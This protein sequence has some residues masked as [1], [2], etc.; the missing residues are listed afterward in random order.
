MPDCA[1]REYTTLDRGNMG[2]MEPVGSSGI[3]EEKH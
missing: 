1:R 3:Q 2:V